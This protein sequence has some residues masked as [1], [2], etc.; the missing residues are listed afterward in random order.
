MPPPDAMGFQI[1][2]TPIEYDIVVGILKM[3]PQ[4]KLFYASLVDM[5]ADWHANGMPEKIDASAKA[6]E[7]LAGFNPA[8]FAAIGTTFSSLEIWMKT[9][10]PLPPEVLVAL[11]VKDFT[12]EFAIRNK[13]LPEAA[14]IT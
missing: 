1:D 4:L 8:F 2:S 12:P 9:P 6:S 3:L 7:T 11:G 5:T 13:W 10:V 14:N